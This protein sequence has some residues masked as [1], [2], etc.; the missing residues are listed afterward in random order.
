MKPQMNKSYS[1]KSVKKGSLKGSAI[2]AK[3]LIDLEYPAVVKSLY[4]E[5]MK[6]EEITLPKSSLVR[7]G[8]HPWPWKRDK[9]ILLAWINGSSQMVYLL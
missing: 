5:Q 2:V 3:A 9:V 6:A 4:Y 8:D 7:S 1:A